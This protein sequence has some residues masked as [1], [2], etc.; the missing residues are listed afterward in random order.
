MVEN[1]T[2]QLRKFYQSLIGQQQVL[3]EKKKDYAIDESPV[4]ILEDEINLLRSQ[5]PDIVPPF[6]RR[7]FEAD[8]VEGYPIYNLAGIR[9][10]LS[11]ALGRL[12]IEIDEPIKTSNSTKDYV[13]TD[14]MKEL[15]QVS[16]YKFDLCKMLRLC[17]ELNEC[18]RTGSIL[19]IIM[20]TRALIDHVPPLFGY[21]SFNEVANNYSG[22]K[23]F[24]ESMERLNASSRKIAD[25][26][27][28]TP[29]RKSESIPTMNQVDFS[30]DIDVLLAEV[31]RILKRP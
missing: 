5:F 27:L 8:R 4:K 1:K 29:I 21:R 25:Q 3:E 13:H 28:H 23:S 22:T 30:N 9:S 11:S 26:H 2:N 18:Y 7:E 12:K 19:S 31:Y 15:R 16:S 17:E 24:K 6:N 20:L 14:R 10:Y